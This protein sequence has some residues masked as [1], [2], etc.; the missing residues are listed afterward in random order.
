M[1]SINRKPPTFEP[2]RPHEYGDS[3]SLPRVLFVDDEANILQ[4]VRRV[5][6]KLH[7]EVETT[8]E[9][10]QAIDMVKQAQYAVVVSDQRMPSMGGVEVLE[11]I[12]AISPETV[13]IILTGYADVKASVDAINKGAVWRY[14]NKPWDD[15]DLRTCV[16]QGV[17]HYLLVQDNRRL[18][19]LTQQQNDRLR[20]L[21][22]NLK[23]RVLERTWEVHRLNEQLEASF[24][25]AVQAMARLG[26]VHSQDVGSHSKRVALLARRI[27]QRFQFEGRD[28]MQVEVAATL[29]DIGKTMIRPSILKKSREELTAE[30]ERVYR[31]HPIHGESILRMV[32]N[33][34]DA[35]LYVR[36]HHE[37]FD[38][39]GY[40]DGF[41]GEAI[42]L[43]ARIIA[44]AD[45]F[46]KHMNHSVTATAI[47]AVALRKVEEGAGAAFD[48]SVV[49]T[50][51]L[52]VREIDSKINA[53]EE[54]Q[55]DF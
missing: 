24:L 19:E 10:E 52:V 41:S 35:A 28:L 6:R 34:D 50:L 14:L 54:V 18:Q 17:N 29:H 1:P 44:V 20:D 48:P 15:D 13:R 9:P 30:E 43:G 7:V 49:S 39:L 38:G 11:R 46:D 47:S 53:R 16:M 22:E 21:N 25:G 31:E 2:T 32:P 5:M 45:A 51:R 37:R 4:S 8:T 12:R 33:N 3:M 42:P 27:A 36:H 26:E 55:I 40:P 23:Q